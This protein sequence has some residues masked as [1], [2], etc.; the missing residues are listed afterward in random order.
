MR[1]M[2]LGISAVLLAASVVSMAAPEPCPP[3][4]EWNRPHKP[5]KLLGN[6]YFV[7]TNGLS[8]VLITSP[9]GHLLIDGGLDMSAPQIAA[10]IA[11]LGFELKDV[12]IIVNSHT[13]YDHA[14]GIA[15]LQRLSGAKVLASP[16]AAQAL[17]TGMPVPSDPQAALQEGFP[18]VAAV[19]EIKDREVLRVGDL[20]VTVHFTPGHTPGGT[21]WTWQSCEANRC[22]NLVYGDSLTAVS[23]D[24]FH[25]SGDKRWPTAAAEFRSTLDKV[26]RLPCDILVTAHPS[27]A[28]LWE[29]LAARDAGNADALVDPNACRAY[30]ASARERLTKRLD[31]ER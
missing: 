18:R 4:E 12:R 30:A 27:I 14:G 16:L 3:C 6:S 24:G 29:K 26:E 23:A 19:E 21:S 1:S 11:K 31:E 15:E 25:F 28:G 13:H 17:R 22:L 5:F 10:N 7:G 20:A 9:A 2:T 8:A